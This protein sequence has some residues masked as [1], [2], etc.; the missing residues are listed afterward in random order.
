MPSSP[1]TMCHSTTTRNPSRPIPLLYCSAGLAFPSCP[2]ASRAPAPPPRQPV[3]HTMDSVLKIFVDG[4]RCSFSWG[5]QKSQAWSHAK[6]M[7][8]AFLI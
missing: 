7:L 6:I 4:R 1:F 8:G 2:L 5:E 3:I